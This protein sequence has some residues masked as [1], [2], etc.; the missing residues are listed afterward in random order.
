MGG[1]F[2]KQHPGGHFHVSCDDDAR[3]WQETGPTAD[4]GRPGPRVSLAG[5]DQRG[6]QA[7]WELAHPPHWQ[8]C[9][10]LTALPP[11]VPLAEGASLCVPLQGTAG[12]QALKVATCSH[13][14]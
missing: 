13:A 12:T 8:L 10:R 6:C 11:R 5:G 9:L 3:T 14:P 1:I 7:E 4:R 2:S